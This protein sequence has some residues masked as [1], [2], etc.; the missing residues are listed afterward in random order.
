V[1]T[2]SDGLEQRSDNFLLLRFIA[3]ALVIYGH[4]PTIAATPGPPDL[5]LWLNWDDY[6]GEIAVDLFFVISGFLI[7]GSYVRRQHLG[8]YIWARFL[9]IVP[10][11]AVCILV[12]AVL[13]GPLFSACAVTEYF[14]DHR[15]YRYIAGNMTY[16]QSLMVW[17]LPGVFLPNA[18]QVVNGSLWTLPAEVVMYVWVAALGLLTV[19]R[20]RWLANVVAIGLFIYGYTYPDHLWL[21]DHRFQHLAMLFA[22]GAFCYVNRAHVPNHGAFLLGAIALAYA[23]RASPVYPYLFTGC[24]VLFVFWFAYKLRWNGFSRF[25][26]CSYGVYLWGFPSQQI[27]AC[28]GYDLPVYAN[29]LLGFALALSLGVASWH[30]IEKP[31]LGLKSLPRSLLDRMARKSSL[32]WSK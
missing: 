31:A 22:V 5:F 7:T 11:Y 21:T 4:A 19:F 12:S 8:D 1:P 18:T 14:A 17:T 25:S 28:L 27:V 2:I 9:R 6:S 15:V 32:V 30:L 29:A 10:A 20:R 26:D 23:L 3:A 16:V 24:E 13:I